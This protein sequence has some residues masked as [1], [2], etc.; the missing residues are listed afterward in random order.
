VRLCKYTIIRKYLIIWFDFETF[1]NSSWLG[2]IDPSHLPIPG[3]TRPEQVPVRLVFLWEKMLYR[4]WSS[5][6]ST[7]HLHLHVFLY[8]MNSHH[9]NNYKHSDKRYFHHFN[10]YKHSAKRY[11][12]HF[13]NYKH[14]DKRYFHHL[15]YYK[16]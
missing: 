5:V 11:F 6:N 10:N 8:Q 7:F 13:N 9:F 14:S 4:S 2:L 15:D 3:K 1:P 12:H 16:N